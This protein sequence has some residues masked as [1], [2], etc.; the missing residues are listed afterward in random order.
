MSASEPTLDEIRRFV[1]DVAEGLD[2]GSR[3]VSELL[4]VIAR[5]RTTAE[6]DARISDPARAAQYRIDGLQVSDGGRG[7]SWLD[8]ET[9]ASMDIW[10]RTL[11]N[12]ITAE[13]R[14]MFR[15]EGK[16]LELLDPVLRRVARGAKADV[17]SVPCSTGKEVYSY[18]IVGLRA[19]LDV[20]VTGVDR[21]RAYVERA[22][23]GKLIYH[24]RDR[25]FADAERWLEVDG[26]RAAR[27]RPEVLARCTFATGDVIAGDLP[28]PAFD[29]VACRNLLGYFRGDALRRALANLAAR[30]REGGVLFLDPYVLGDP[31]LAAA[32][33]WLEEHGWRRLE[34]SASYLV[35]A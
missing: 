18:A 19:G 13:T 30:V 34:A 28:A 33:R 32:P 14:M 8:E 29:L 35:R 12:L 17:L 9:W 23:T 27:V 20:R 16:D 21:Q 11:A 7:L 2:H 22:R 4:D 26:P 3:Y 25:E 31:Q 24:W 5:C 10:E 1:R 6:Y 15:F